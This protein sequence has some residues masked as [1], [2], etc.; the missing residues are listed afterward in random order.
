MKKLFTRTALHGP[1]LTPALTARTWTTHQV[2]ILISSFFL[3]HLLAS[4][5]HPFF[6]EEQMPTILLSTTLLV[7]AI[8]WAVVSRII[9]YRGSSWAIDF[10]MGMPQIKAL[11]LSPLL[12][13]VFMPFLLATTKAYHLVLQQI[14]GIEITL[15]SAAQAILQ[16]QSWL[17]VLYI[18][19]AILAAPLVEEL[20][21]RGILFPYLAKRAGL[22]GGTLLVSVFFAT[23]HFH[24]PSFL[25]L[26]LLSAA[27][28][29][30]YWRTGSLWIC[31]GMHAL[32][33][34]VSILAL[35]IAG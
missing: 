24:L 4:A 33:N 34:A 19:T 9:R 26:F 10:G 1:A 29:I 25:P 28:C 13:L 21:F 17:K 27:L 35:S 11:I 8:T 12:Y 16:E 32:F 30:A 2:G 3:I 5:T 23:I 15:Q 22:A 7:Y 31:I 20:I 6:C 18:S 14:F